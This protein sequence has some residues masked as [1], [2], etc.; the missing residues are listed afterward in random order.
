MEVQPTDFLKMTDEHIQVI[1]LSFIMIHFLE[2]YK[3]VKHLLP[4]LSEIRLALDSATGNIHIVY[5]KEDLKQFDYWCNF[6]DI[7]KRLMN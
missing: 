7:E 6:V 5:K 1:G 3:N 4:E 2:N